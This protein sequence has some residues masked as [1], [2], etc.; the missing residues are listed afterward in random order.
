M[1]KEELYKKIVKPTF[2]Y[3]VDKAIVEE[4]LLNTLDEFFSQNVVI[5][6]GENRHPYADVLHE[7]VEGARIEQQ[8]N[9]MTFAPLEKA[10]KLLSALSYRIKP[11]EVYEYKY[12]LWYCGKK[13]IS[14][15]YL[16]EDEFATLNTQQT[17]ELLEETKR[18]RK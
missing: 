1:T 12:A 7:W 11:Q 5:P 17:V 18:I 9:N 3:K 8:F 2:G 15:N 6:K 13:F 4:Y 14:D 16:T 10:I